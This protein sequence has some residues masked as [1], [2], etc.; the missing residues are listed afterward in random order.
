MER[1]V[2]ENEWIGW[3]NPG[4]AVEWPDQNRSSQ[5]PA[6]KS[7]CQRLLTSRNAHTL[8]LGLVLGLFVFAGSL[9]Q[10]F[11]TP[12]D[13]QPR[14][15]PLMAVTDRPPD[16]PAAKAAE[17][18]FFT[19]KKGTILAMS[20]Q[21]AVDLNPGA[22]AVARLLFDLWAGDDSWLSLAPAGSAIYGSAGRDAEGEAQITWTR[23]V[24]PD[25]G[26][27]NLVP[28]GTN[29]YGSVF[30]ISL[31]PTIAAGTDLTAFVDSDVIIPRAQME[32][33]GAAP[34]ETAGNQDN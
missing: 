7:A 25:G 33:G 24:R 31:D 28:E 26:T 30:T 14:S 27:L 12:Q 18:A 32:G 4:P 1:E 8:F 21:G 2:E 10:V 3:D 13:K 29:G 5:A 20:M 34:Q 19:L 6:A 23:V 9:C 22:T 16:V 11:S 17:P 15:I